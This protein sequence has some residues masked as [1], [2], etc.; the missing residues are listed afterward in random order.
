MMQ[1]VVRGDIL[2]DDKPYEALWPGGRHSTASWQV[3]FL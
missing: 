3:S 2:I 1:T